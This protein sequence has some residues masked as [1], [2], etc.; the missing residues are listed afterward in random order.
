MFEQ[1]FCDLIVAKKAMALSLE[2]YR[3]ARRLPPE[4][5]YLARDMCNTVLIAHSKM[6]RGYANV[7]A[8]DRRRS[9]SRAFGKIAR[10]EHQF[11]MVE[12]LELLPPCNLQEGRIVLGEVRRLLAVLENAWYDS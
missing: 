12:M 9:F 4:D 6:A 5:R 3:I 11:I 7:S 2:V 8:R 10:L 1:Q